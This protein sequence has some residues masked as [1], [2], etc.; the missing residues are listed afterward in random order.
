MTSRETDSIFNKKSAILLAAV[1]SGL[2][3]YFAN[4]LSGNFGYLLWIAPVPV[5]LVSLNSSAKAAFFISFAAY[6]IGRLSWFSYLV[7]VATLAP[8]IMFTILLA[9]IFATI[10]WASLKII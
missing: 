1:I 5:F 3:W 2:C 9:L 10:F 7:R 8:A 6:L 4:S